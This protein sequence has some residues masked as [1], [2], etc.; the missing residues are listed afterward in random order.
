MEIKDIIDA[1]EKETSDLKSLLSKKPEE[2]NEEENL[3]IY[4]CKKS[5]KL[6]FWINFSGVFSVYIS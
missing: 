2:F 3:K 5:L 4:Q 1:F 6:A